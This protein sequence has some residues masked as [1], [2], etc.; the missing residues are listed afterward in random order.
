MILH[1]QPRVLL[2]WG[3]LFINGITSILRSHFI[4]TIAS[5]YN[6]LLSH[7]LQT[8]KKIGHT[9]LLRLPTIASCLFFPQRLS[10]HF[11]GQI[12][13]SLN[14]RLG[15]PKGRG[16]WS[17]WYT[18]LLASRALWVFNSWKR[19][20][21]WGWQIERKFSA[22]QFIQLVG[23]LFSEGTRYISIYQKKFLKYGGENSPPFFDIPI[24]IHHF[25]SK[26]LRFFEAWNPKK[27]SKRKARNLFLAGCCHLS[28][29]KKNL[30]LSMKS[31]F[32]NDGILISS[33]MKQSLYNW[34]SYFIPYI[35]QAT[36]EFFVAHLQ[37][38][39]VSSP[40]ILFYGEVSTLF[41]QKILRFVW[42]REP[43]L[44]IGCS[45]CVVT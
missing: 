37:G 15:W 43:H 34:G 1:Y 32:V 38:V 20:I 4:G 45:G 28:H 24:F 40:E 10:H 39:F 25:I 18:T 42:L 9:S 35:I 44:V 11:F 6:L 31:W 23:S 29:Q 36:R 33:F 8:N 5:R 12:C 14:P 30:L 3:T 41:C 21:Q 19:N 22:V 26:K 16:A 2:L 17:K 13:E 7:F 27:T